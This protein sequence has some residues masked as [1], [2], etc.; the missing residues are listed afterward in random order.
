MGHRLVLRERN[1]SSCPGCDR[2]GRKDFLENGLCTKAIS[3][4]DQL[5][6]RCVGDWAYDKIYRLVQY[7]GIFA[8]GMKNAWQGLNYVEICSGPGRCI[9]RDKRSEIDGTAL[10]I[11]THPVFP[12]L[13]KALFIDADAV[14]VE[15]LNNRIAAVNATNI[16]QAVVGDYNDPEGISMLLAELP[17]KCL[18]LVFLDPTECDLPFATIQA[19]ANQLKN[20]DLI[21]NVAL[22]TDVNRNLVMAINDASF[23]KVKAK[24]ERFLGSPGFCARPK[25]VQL[26]EA[27]DHSELRRLFMAEYI[28]NLAAEGYEFTDTQPVEHYYH[29]LFASRHPRGLEFW[30]NACKIGPDNQRQLL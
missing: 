21:I 29:L 23:G 18:N 4:L 13:K 19:I 1:N 14:V 22:R 16:A 8:N 10:S 15:T 5:P 6:V 20:A 25:I 9:L 12:K 7:F 30:K 28:G 27:G 26:A 24:Y 3:V 17:R 11:L 2:I